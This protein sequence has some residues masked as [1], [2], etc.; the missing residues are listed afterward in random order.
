MQR[1]R[2][3]TRAATLS[4]AGLSAVAVPAIAQ[5]APSVKW[6]MST[7]WPKSLDTIYGSADELCKRVGA[8]T[9]GKFDIRAFPAGEMVPVAQNMDAVSNG[10]VECNHVL[11]TF[12]IGKNTALAFDTGLSFGM[13]ARQHNAWLLYG[14]GMDM[15]R[16]L[17]GKYGIMNFTCGN[18][19]VQMGGWFRKEI[20]SVADLKGLKMRI[21]GIGGMVMTK[22]GVVPQQIPAGD[23]YSA[24]EKGTMDASEWIGPYDDEKLGLNKVAP[25]YYAPGWW[26]GSASI[27]TM[28]N[29]KAFEALPAQYKAAFEVACNE[30]NLKMLAH[31]DAVNPGAMRKLIAAGAQVRFFPKDV[32]DASYTASQELWTEL[33]AKNPDFA[34]IFPEWKKFQQEEVSWFRVAENSL[35]NYT[36]AAVLRR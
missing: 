29:Q 33:T 13:N 9:D 27:T 8:L 36:S 15:L 3:L 6:R 35:D 25:Y 10:T 5:T 31:Y 14:G 16:K 26:E 23:I 34:A 17:Y 30:Q 1:R 18:V 11:S 22:L 2:F 12:Y 28:V 19:G 32:M 24:L 20:K 7:S 21:G 4:G